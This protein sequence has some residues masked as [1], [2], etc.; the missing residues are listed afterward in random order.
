MFTSFPR[1]VSWA[2]PVLQASRVPLG[3][4]KAV[5]MEQE[6]G[7]AS[8]WATPFWSP[9]AIFDIHHQKMQ[10]QGPDLCRWG[11]GCGRKWGAH[12]VRIVHSSRSKFGK[13]CFSKT[14]CAHS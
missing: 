12:G 13:K 9:H 3:E 11:F 14:E 2:I 7:G 4:Q 6:G 8:A 5:L 1:D 10:V